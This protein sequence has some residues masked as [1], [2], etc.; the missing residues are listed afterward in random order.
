VEPSSYSGEVVPVPEAFER[1][2][3]DPTVTEAGRLRM[4]A[5]AEGYVST[6][7]RDAL[8]PYSKE[9][10]STI[11]WQWH[12]PS[13]G[14]KRLGRDN[15]PKWEKYLRAILGRFG[16]HPTVLAWDLMNEPNCIR[17]F[18]VPAGGG[19][20]FDQTIVYAFVDRM[21]DVAES[22]KPR[23]PITIGTESRKAMHEL[24]S[25][26]EILS[27]H[28]YEADPSQL[29][30]MVQ[31]E[32][33]FA[34]AQSKPL[35]LTESVALLF[36]RSAMDTGDAAQLELYRRS[37]PVLEA[38]GVGYYLVALMAGRFP[39]AWVGYFRPDGTRKVVADYIESVL[40]HQAPL[41]P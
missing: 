25:H 36:V 31:E 21:R 8:C 38:A 10:P 35:L 29:A 23:K 12:A 24:A 3:K 16:D 14:Y 41:S 30:K 34:K 26:A 17:I 40:K 28:T 22:I 2:M 20:P 33:T 19:L 27:F 4:R 11:L 15:W 5:L 1:A 9:D 13:P 39:F 37:L 6:A 32:A 18:N 7:G